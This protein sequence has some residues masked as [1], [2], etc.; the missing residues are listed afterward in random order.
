MSWKLAIDAIRTTTPT[1]LEY[2]AEQNPPD[3]SSVTTVWGTRR[4]TGEII[5]L[6]RDSSNYVSI[7]ESYPDKTHTV[8]RTQYDPVQAHAL[9]A[10]ID[11]AFEG[12]RSS[13][14]AIWV[15][16]K[17]LRGWPLIA[18]DKRRAILDV[19][20]VENTTKTFPYSFF[21]GDTNVPDAREFQSEISEITSVLI[22]YVY[23]VMEVWSGGLSRD[24]Q[25][26]YYA[27]FF[28]TEPTISYHE[29]QAIWQQYT[30][31]NQG[32]NQA[33]GGR[34]LRSVFRIRERMLQLVQ[35]RLSLVA[36]IE[37]IYHDAT[38]L[39]DA[40]EIVEG[41][42]SL[43]RA[44]YTAWSPIAKFFCDLQLHIDRLILAAVG[45]N[46]SGDLY[47]NLL[48]VYDIT[49]A[50]LRTMWG[51]SGFNDD[52]MNNLKTLCF[53]VGNKSFRENYY[54][55]A[56]AFALGELDAIPRLT[57]NDYTIDGDFQF[58]EQNLYNPLLFRGFDGSGGLGSLDNQVVALHAGTITQTPINLKT[59]QPRN[60]YHYRKTACL[61]FDTFNLGG[62][63]RPPVAQADITRI[64]RR[65]N[66]LAQWQPSLARIATTDASDDS[67][68]TYASLNTINPVH[69]LRELITDDTVGLGYLEARLDE[70][71]FIAAA[72]TCFDERLGCN[73]ANISKTKAKPLI[74]MLRG[75]MSCEVYLDTLSDEIKIKLIRYIDDDDP[76]PTLDETN[77]NSVSQFQRNYNA[78]PIS[79]LTIKYLN[80]ANEP[81]TINVVAPNFSRQ[82]GVQNIVYDCCPDERTAKIVASRDLAIANNSPLTMTAL[83]DFATGYPFGLG[84]A[85]RVSWRAYEIDMML[86]R[87]IDKTLRPNNLI[88]LKLMQDLFVPLTTDLTE[89]QTRVIKE[90][91]EGGWGN[92]W[93]LSFGD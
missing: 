57:F 22:G 70:S 74:E 76:L 24:E 78:K 54:S 18:I 39:A 77:V 89:E 79:A 29:A 55:G 44:S 34:I 37:H 32:G 90:S 88:E 25:Q 60:D 59:R 56:Y 27:A 49:M 26:E 73:Y 53:I 50:T 11:N 7:R 66:G 6:S 1:R 80:Y 67:P 69:M 21:F 52:A 93:D 63:E 12:F 3:K 2:Q 33:V 46:T 68:E 28:G 16:D 38:R 72:Q 61:T 75:Y 13:L 86:A 20:P 15:E 87:V 23:A 14:G 85:V 64:M 19:R 62:D 45:I 4:V 43:L 17:V 10:N 40:G 58:G 47:R 36:R 81:Q 30:D 71:S 31:F 9:A 5:E 41:V 51:V 48:S 92:A 42:G 84:D 91:V 82:S 65:L 8:K 83:V 35:R